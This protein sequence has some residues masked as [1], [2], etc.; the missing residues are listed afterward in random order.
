MQ[1]KNHP[2]DEIH[3]KT[4]MFMHEQLENTDAQIVASTLL[5][6]AMRLYKTILT[7]SDFEKFMNVIANELDKIEPFDRPSI[8]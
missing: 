8:N 6:I 4:M 7:P 3:R 1:N 2:L 5:A